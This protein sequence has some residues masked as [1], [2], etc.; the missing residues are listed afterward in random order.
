M[1]ARRLT[2]LALVM[3]AVAGGFDAWRAWVARTELPPLLAEVSTEVRAADGALLRVFPVENGRWRLAVSVADVDPAFIQM[4]V[5]YE[6]KRF[7]QHSGVDGRAMLRA[8]WQ[9][10]RHGR[11]VSGGSTLTMQAARLVENSGTGAWRG[12]IR[13]MRVAWAL[14]ARLTKAQILGLY[15]QHAPYGGPVEGI[16]SGARAWFGKAPRR[17]RAEEAALLIALPQAPETRR[18]D[19]HPDAAMQARNRVLA[20]LDLP[21]SSAKVPERMTA[22]PRLAP[23]LTD[24]LHAA[25]PAR[26]RIDT[27]L[28][29]GVQRALQTLAA[30][31]VQTQPKGVS[32][33]ILVADHRTGQIRAS[34]GSARYAP[35]RLGF[36]DM[37]RAVRSPGSTLKPLIF[38]LAFDAGLAHPETI[39]RDV[40]TDFGGY[41]PCN[42][43]GTYRGEVTARQALRASLNIPPVALT[44]ALGPA[45]LVAT[46]R[47]GGAD[48]KLRGAPGLAVALGGVGVSLT[49]LVTLYAGL[50]RGGE[51]ITLHAADA[52][53]GVGARIVA[54]RN[55]WHVG[56]MLR[57]TVPGTGQI[58]VKTGTSYG[59]R[60]AWAIGWDG[61]HVVGVWLGRPDGTPVPGAF[62]AES[63]VPILREAFGRL[64]AAPTPLPPPPRDALLLSTAE[65]PAPLQ[66]FGAAQARADA[67]AV[68]FPPDGA[69]LAAAQNLVVKVR[70]GHL[71]LTVFV[72]GAP[73][74]T[75]LRSRTAHLPWPGPGF[76]RIAVVDASGQ[77]SAVRVRMAE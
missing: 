41:A 11:V 1:T 58:A 6:D 59:H 7:W 16:R 33:A 68:A 23:H 76:S 55:A 21:A 3:L 34:V 30:E 35:G 8:A 69:E 54:A 38:A 37:T 43:D 65:L 60:D 42:F 18:P 10:L 49:D 31:A 28:D 40:P 63:A 5:A 24:A 29:A 20:R 51:A 71:P 67:P 4:L 2:A 74:V 25:D 48:P 75:G 57:G 47:R 52:P 53:A 12:K 15:L 26:Q 39:L 64:S 14:E 45:R 72:N 36:V 13:Q 70:G 19:R 50:A 17:L 56:D 22:L 27:S 66:R 77:S 44:E 46:M 73:A 32:A 62:G 9:A 61:R